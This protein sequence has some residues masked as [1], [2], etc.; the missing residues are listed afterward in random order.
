MFRERNKADKICI[1]LWYPP[2]LTTILG[3]TSSVA[4]KHHIS[5]SHCKEARGVLSL[6]L[7]VPC[8]LRCVNP[9]SQRQQAGV[10][11]FYHGRNEWHVVWLEATT[12][13]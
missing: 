8:R 9:G 1:H 3:A 4:R 6:D 13:E 2:L 12:Y 5:P 11:S 10:L 7:T